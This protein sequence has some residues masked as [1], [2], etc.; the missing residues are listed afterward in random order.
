MAGVRIGLSK[1]HFSVPSK[2]IYHAILRATAARAIRRTLLEAGA[3]PD[4]VDLEPE[5]GRR[6]QGGSSI[7]TTPARNIMMLACAPHSLS[8]RM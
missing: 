4:H 1:G 3:H 5:S 8:T 6:G 7:L 2:R